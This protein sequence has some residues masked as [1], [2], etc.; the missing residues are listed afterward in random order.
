MEVR[1]NNLRLAY[2]EYKA[3]P[4]PM[5]FG[6]TR[7][8]AR[9]GLAINTLSNRSMDWQLRMRRMI[10]WMEEYV[11]LERRINDELSRL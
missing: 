2:N 4:P 7:G 1:L 8:F 3:C 5:E 6:G 10:T 9:P 11:V